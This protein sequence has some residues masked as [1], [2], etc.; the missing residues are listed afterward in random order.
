MINYR[1]PSTLLYGLLLIFLVSGCEQNLHNSKNLSETSLQYQPSAQNVFNRAIDQKRLNNIACSTQDQ[2]LFKPDEK[3][4]LIVGD[5]QVVDLN[6]FSTTETGT[7]NLTFHYSESLLSGSVVFTET[8]PT[9]VHVHQSFA[10]QTGDLIFALVQSTTNP[11]VWNIES[12]TDPMTGT[13]SN[14]IDVDTLL[15]GGYYINVHFG[16]EVNSPTLRA[17]ITNDNIKTQFALLVAHKGIIT[18]ASGFSG[19][20]INENKCNISAYITLTD[21][22]DVSGVHLHIEDENAS[23]RKYF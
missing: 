10:G 5:T 12:T 17:Q 19:V 16:N 2:F 4:A 23:T 3:I 20:S 6:S 21:V 18:T 9:K 11:A 1:G 7:A 15:A 13:L 14:M 8:E 22:V